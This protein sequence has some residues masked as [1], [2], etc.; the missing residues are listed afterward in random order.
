M[1]RRFLLALVFLAA[2]TGAASAVG[3]TGTG[4]CF[5]EG[6]TGNWSD[7][8]KWCTTDTNP[9][10][11]STGGLPG[12]T[13][14]CKFTANSNT[15]AYTVTLNTTGTCLDL[16]WALPSASGVPTF[17]MGTNNISVAGSLTAITGMSFS[18][19]NNI[20]SFTSTATGKTITSNGVTFVT[21]N[22]T[23][24]GTGG[25]WTLQDNLTM[26]HPTGAGGQVAVLAGT[27]N[28]NAKTVS[29]YNLQS[30]SGTRTLTFDNSTFNIDGVAGSP[31]NV[32]T[33]GTLT[34]S[35][36]GSTINYSGGTAA[37]QTNFVTGGSTYGAINIT[38][39]GTVVL[40][41]SN[42]TIKNFSYTSTTDKRDN[43][44]FNSLWSIGAS[45]S[46]TIAGNSSV[47]R[48]FVTSNGIGTQRQV[49][50]PNTATVTLTNV[51]FQDISSGGTFGTWTGTSL[52]D[53]L[54]NTGVT[55]DGSTTQTYAGGTNNWST[56]AAWTSRVPLCQD[57]VVVNTTT[58]GTLTGDM[59][60]LG[61]N[62]NFTSFTRTFS[63]SIATASFGN[64]TLSSGMTLSETNNWGFSGRGAQTFTT[65]GKTFSQ[66]IFFNGPGGT[67]TL[68]DS[69]IYGALSGV[70][71][72]VLSGASLNANGFDVGMFGMTVNTTGTLTMGSG[73]WNLNA[74][75]GTPWSYIAGT[76][77]PGTSTIKILGA[78][79]SA[80]LTFGG[81]GKTYNN[82]WWSD[83]AATG[84]LIV[85]GAN[86]FNDFKVDGTTGRTVQFP[87]STTNVFS[88]FTVS[89]SSASNKISLTSSTP[90]TPATLSKSSG[91]VFS[92]F[93]TVQDSTATG[94]ATWVAC[95][96]TSVSGNSGW[97]FTCGGG[98]LMTL[99]VGG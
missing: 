3:C 49:T 54:G 25:G 21:T 19:G 27:L 51:D 99:G 53:C 90:G 83:T 40:A 85:T 18:G 78:S 32:T 84:T 4:N 12:T 38:A 1:I 89:G 79:G 94:G 17:S 41:P 33:T 91:L 65:N 97:K 98:G 52:G 63:H 55:F 14:N 43:L 59:P 82:L 47:N 76:L 62:I 22:F 24:N 75:V 45:G 72:Q 2:L 28:T 88:T 87:A 23:F 86:T 56:A 44:Q 92:R 77:V 29:L 37:T 60:R 70:S 7:T 57:D 64:L 11:G 9:C 10:S 8:T 35:A 66:T 93:L 68:Q 5:W 46:L 31:W 58:A 48:A 69:F 34:F 36:T 74:T 30:T 95:S 81:G 50:V 39:T 13:D 15:T 20:V 67:Y 16:T 73:T 6:G 42:S 80:N 71:I 61:R 26:T 96:S